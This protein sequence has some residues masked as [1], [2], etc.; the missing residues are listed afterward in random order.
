MILRQ[1]RLGNLV[2]AGLWG[3]T[4]TDKVNSTLGHVNKR[5]IKV[6]TAHNVDRTWTGTVF[7]ILH[8]SGFC[9]VGCLEKQGACMRLL[10]ISIIFIYCSG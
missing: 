10:L 3:F 1:S 6:W 4:G 9:A 2:T 7:L 8:F 5:G